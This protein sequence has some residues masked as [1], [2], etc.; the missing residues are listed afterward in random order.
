[1]KTK[2]FTLMSVLL[3]LFSSVTFADR[4]LNRAEI[5]QIFQQLTSQP[6]KTW[7]PAGTIKATHEEYRSPK[8]TDIN[9]INGQIKEKIAEYQNNQNKRELTEDLQKMKLDAMSFNVRHKLS[10]EYTMNSSV[11]VKFD[12]ERFYWE[13]NMD[14]R[15][16]SVKPGKD[17]TDNL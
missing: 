2:H 8:T 15:T 11:I 7:I 3:L 14:S 5:L 1:M 6:K 4:P 9:E 16:D 17:L 13:I 10:N 12:G